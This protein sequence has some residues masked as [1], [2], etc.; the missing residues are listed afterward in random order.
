MK[1]FKV[2][3][4]GCKVNQYDSQAIREQLEGIGLTELG[5]GK[6][7]DCYI[8]N[9]CTVTQSADKQSRYLLRAAKRQNPSAKIIA[10][11]CYAHSNAE[12]IKRIGGVDLI[13]N[14]DD[15]QRIAE[16]VFDNKSIQI[17]S[18]E[19]SDFKSHTRAFVKIQDGCNNFCSFC[20][21]P[22]VRGRS[23]S[24]N[25]DSII[26]EINRLSDRG[27]KEIV[28]TGICIGD[29]GR[30]LQSKIDLVD[31]IAEIEKIKE[32]LRI[33][34]SSIEAKD[35]TDKLIKA[36]RSSKKLCPHLHIPFQS[37][38]NKILKLMNRRD[39]RES[40]LE[41]VRK[42]RKN[43]RNLA[44]TCDIMIGFVGEE[45]NNFSNTLEFLKRVKP[46]RIH[47]FT[48]QARD[49]TPLANSKSNIASEILKQRYL[50]IKELSDKLGLNLR[51]NLL[52][53]NLEILF[54]D[55][56][57]GFWRGYSNNYLLTYLERNAK[58]S[59]ENKLRKIKIYN[60]SHSILFSK[61]ER[62]IK[63]KCQKK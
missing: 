27:Y 52:N 20:K 12:D 55:R 8:V 61:K 36:M 22:F 63:P 17:G 60:C 3:T 41:L 18:F 57:D 19:I 11:G 29:Y 10:T 5:N 40:Y 2:Y 1:T 44:I 23:R 39:T 42:L 56:K 34:I 13:L 28:L 4:L 33:R 38:D 43:I 30:D 45:E 21:V 50:R 26:E 32:I 7:A 47:I 58:L 37:G 48:F 31:L 16:F 35:I 15:K 51:K 14:N 6:K 9:T 24:R 49:K 53:K 46:A 25:P 59:L 62:L 54:E